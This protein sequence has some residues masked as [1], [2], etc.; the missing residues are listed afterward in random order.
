MWTVGWDK[1]LQLSALILSVVNGLIL[2]RVHLRDRARLRVS[3]IHPDTYQWWFRVPPGTH[4]DH[5]TR[6]FGFVVYAGI[7]NRGYRAVTINRWRLQ[8]GIRATGRLIPIL[9][10]MMKRMRDRAA[11]A[12]KADSLMY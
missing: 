4:A 7:D 2:V 6:R 3:P 11:N 12:K 9:F 8:D 5:P 1:L 10:A